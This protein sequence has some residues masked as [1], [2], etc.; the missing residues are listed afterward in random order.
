MA[1]AS[2]EMSSAK[3]RE[4]MML[5]I[6]VKKVAS[7]SESIVCVVLQRDLLRVS[8]YVSMFLS[9]LPLLHLLRSR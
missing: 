3:R 8:C 6:S 4:E 9:S 5:K 1:V 2:A 7:P